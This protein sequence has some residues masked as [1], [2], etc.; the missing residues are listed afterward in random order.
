MTASP[1]LPFDDRGFAYGDGLFETVLLRDGKPVLWDFHRARLRRG[2]E[3]LGIETPDDASLEATW[4]VDSPISREEVL[5][6][7]VTRGSG[8]RGYAPPPTPSPRLLSHRTPFKPNL[9]RWQEGVQVGVCDLR[10]GHQP[11]LAGIKHLNRLENVL[12]RREWQR[13]DIAE[14][15]LADQQG[16]LVE[17]T[18][19]NLF[20]QKGGAFWT[21]PIV[22]CGVAGTL[23]EAL[24]AQGD[25]QEAK[26]PL[27]DLPM[28]DQL[29][30]GNSVQGL[31]PVVA[32]V[33]FEGKVQ[34]RWSRLESDSL[35]RAGHRL[36][37]FVS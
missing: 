31:W 5:K 6:I 8:G 13:D 34:K 12:A 18:S 1:M 17:A 9:M 16:N 29:W 10:L 32:L 33:S 37:G 20:W 2:C 26:L 3:V 11:R 21:P 27:H 36:L 7:V 24:I 35:Q 25:V 28:V 19:M 22:Q 4:Q 14:G 15:L 23:R 30:V